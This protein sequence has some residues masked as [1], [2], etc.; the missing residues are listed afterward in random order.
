LFEAPVVSSEPNTS[1]ELTPA[2]IAQPAVD[3][4]TPFQMQ[5]DRFG[6]FCDPRQTDFP[7]RFADRIV[8]F[9]TFYE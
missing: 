6:A 3:F 1:Q 9:E 2:A 7:T 4:I 5:L 8:V